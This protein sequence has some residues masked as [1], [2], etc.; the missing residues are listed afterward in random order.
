[1][2][3]SLIAQDVDENVTR[4][5]GHQILPSVRLASYTR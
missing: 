3:Y 5:S 4:A 2:G 1:V